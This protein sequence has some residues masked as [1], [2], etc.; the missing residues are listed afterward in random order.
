[1]RVA[2]VQFWL[3]G[4]GGSE[5]VLEALGEI[6]PQADFYALVVA[7]GGIP[8]SLR[9]RKWTTSFVDRIPGAR[10]WYRNL[11]PL[12]PFA[13]EQFDLSEYDLVISSESGPAKGVITSPRSCHICYCLSPMRYVWDMYHEY[14]RKMNPLARA[15]FSLAAHYARQWDVTTAARVDYFA[16]ISDYV[17]AR[18]RKYY[19]R[20]STV[21]YPPVD[22]SKGYLADKTEDY[23]LAISRL[24]PYK[25]VDL[26]IE[27]CTRLGR[28][29]RVVGT[30][31]ELKRLKAMAG[32]T[33]EF[34]GRLDD[35]SLRECY[36]RSRAFL[37]PAEEDFG[38]APVEAQSF[39]RPVIAYGRGG[40]IETV[41]GLADGGDPRSATGIFFREQT[42]ES[43]A[44]AIVRFEETESTFNPEFIRASAQRFS[45]ERFKEEF[46][47]FAA[48]RLA[49]FQEES[50][51]L[52]QPKESADLMRVPAGGQG[53]AY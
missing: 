12:Y 31:P 21:I 9:G 40:A 39:G 35:A 10:R 50:G 2:V 47:K 48:G 53:G 25:R 42:A 28:R 34:M 16:A 18:V 14:R 1:M 24:V 4:Y 32:P 17:A 41:V 38:I 6:F 11:L 43:L 44:G 19:R 37:F 23:Y 33:V 49:E 8:A 30:G 52:P 26:A 3:S 51:G 22:V 15:A 45:L 5:K 36:A 7:D 46:V 20:E 29:L 27:A 13:L